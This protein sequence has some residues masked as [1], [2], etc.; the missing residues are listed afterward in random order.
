MTALDALILTVALLALVISVA[1]YLRGAPAALRDLAEHAARTATR[2]VDDFAA[3]KSQAQTIL[4][5]IED[6]RERTERAAAR[7]TAR[8]H[9]MKQRIEQ[10][11]GG[12]EEQVSGREGEMLQ[13]R[14]R[15]GIL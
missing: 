2:V 5:A 12:G 6:E 8:D 4:G 10:A 15:A 11:E 13:L 1:T 14:K 3:F 7:A 9:R